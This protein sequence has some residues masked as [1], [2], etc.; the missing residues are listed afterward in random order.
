M[1]KKQDRGPLVKL[2]FG[3]SHYIA[4]S[5]MRL[6]AAAGILVL[7]CASSIAVSQSSDEKASIPDWV[8]PAGNA[9]L[10]L[11]GV[12]L[13]LIMAPTPKPADYADI[14]A[15]A[16][17]EIAEMSRSTGAL[18]ERLATVAVLDELTGATT[19]KVHLALVEQELARQQD[20]HVREIARWSRVAPGSDDEIVKGRETTASILKK[21]ER[22]QGNAREY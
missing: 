11:G 3:S 6:W 2:E 22:K 20:V 10:T 4:L 7:L 16:V 17:D 14:A 1:K 18:I 12:A 21:L 8:Q 19:A 9:G 13:G 15:I 5:R